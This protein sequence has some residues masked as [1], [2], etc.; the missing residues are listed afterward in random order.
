MCIVILSYVSLICL[1]V[2]FLECY[3]F[4]STLFSTAIEDIGYTTLKI[5]YHFNSSFTHG[6]TMSNY[7]NQNGGF[8]APQNTSARLQMP[9]MSELGGRNQVP[10]VRIPFFPTSPYTSTDANVGT[11]VR[12]YGGTLTSGDADV[13]TNSESIRTVQFDIPC[14]LIAINA[15]CVD[16]STTA[17]TYENLLNCFLFRMEYTTGDKLHTSARLASTV[18]GSMENPGEIGSSGYTI[19]QGAS[20]ILGITP[21]GNLPTNYR[22]DITLVCLEIRGNRNFV[23]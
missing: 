6:E 9:T 8:S 13:Q 7:Y 11:Q 4:H 16:T 1:D 18:C 14:R 17:T 3:S 15:A 19:D 20:V 5:G 10:W 12:Y 21:L 23:G 2:F 22:I